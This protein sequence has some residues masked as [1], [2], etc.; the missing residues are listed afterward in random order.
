MGVAVDVFG[1][2]EQGDV[3][4]DGVG[5]GE[6]FEDREV[7][8]AGFFRLQL[9]GGFEAGDADEV[10]G[11]LAVVEVAT[12]VT[13]GAV[14]G[15]LVAEAGKVVVGTVAGCGVDAAGAGFS[16]DVVG[17]DDGAG[18]VDKRVA[19][20]EVFELCARNDQRVRRAGLD[21]R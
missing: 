20:G 9:F 2:G 15:K 19:G 12:V 11:D 5:G 1:L 14:N 16:G 10:G 8:G 13:D 18:A 6:F 21:D 4:G 17:D 3:A 7:R